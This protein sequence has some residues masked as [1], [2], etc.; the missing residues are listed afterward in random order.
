MPYFIWIC[1]VV[2][3]ICVSAIMY[4]RGR[5]DTLRWSTE[6]RQWIADGNRR[7]PMPEIRINWLHLVP[8]AIFVIVAA[9]LTAPGV[10]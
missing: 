4:L 8:P 10:Y 2:I 1:T 3:V 9:L 5:I 6:C 7:S